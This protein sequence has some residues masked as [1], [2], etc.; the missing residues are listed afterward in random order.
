M[1]AYLQALPLHLSLFLVI[2]T[3]VA[4]FIV[5]SVVVNSIYT[6]AELAVNNEVAGSKFTFLA[7]TVTTLVAFVLVDS[8][9]RFVSFQFAVDREIS[10]ITRLENLQTAFPK[11]LQ[12]LNID[13]K[14]YL[15]SV[16][17]TEWQSMGDG[18]GSEVTE[19]SIQ[20]WFKDFVLIKASDEGEA[21]VLN[22]YGRI[23]GDM[24]DYRLTRISSSSSPFDF[25]CQI[26][27]L[28]AGVITIVFCWFFGS[29]NTFMKLLLGGLLVGSTFAVIAMSIILA[30]PVRG[31]L[32]Y[33]TH[34]YQSLIAQ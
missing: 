5:G 14:A 30:S 15:V 27:V 10:A 20:K 9:T 3:G 32:A 18:N 8:A 29:T 34:V 22:L 19:K 6:P 12:P 16:I 13:T 23:F 31:D 17:E 33:T 11:L 28:I 2:G 1:F 25:L 7:Q 21:A 26:S 4:I 24:N